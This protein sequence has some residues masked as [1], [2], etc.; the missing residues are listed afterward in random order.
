MKTLS[1]ECPKKVKKA[2]SLPLSQVPINQA[3]QIIEAIQNYAS[4]TQATITV[5]LTIF[6]ENGEGEVSDKVKISRDSSTNLLLILRQIL[7]S[8]QYVNYPSEMKQEFLNVVQEDLKVPNLTAEVP[9]Q[10]VPSNQSKK[11]LSKV[12]VS[13]EFPWAMFLLIIANVFVLSLF[14]FFSGVVMKLILLKVLAFALPLIAILIFITVRQLYLFKLRNQTANVS[15][16]VEKDTN[17]QINKSTQNTFIKEEVTSELPP[18]PE[19]PVDDMNENLSKA[20][21]IEFPAETTVEENISI[22]PQKTGTEE[23]LIESPKKEKDNMP[24]N[25]AETVAEELP[26]FSVQ[27]THQSHA[28]ATDYFSFEGLSAK[29]WRTEKLKQ[30]EHDVMLAKRKDGAGIVEKEK[31]LEAIH[32]NSRADGVKAMMLIEEIANMKMSLEAKWE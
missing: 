26:D 7:S 12:A 4:K 21:N 32:V 2:L 25:I 28:P 22:F 18:M 13:S 30:L 20:T 1:F 8:E 23:P 6:D 15:S 14:V 5:G 10:K 29:E 9:S 19:P 31:E 3:T 27:T 11:S 24:T 16:E 17:I